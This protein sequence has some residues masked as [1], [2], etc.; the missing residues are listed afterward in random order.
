MKGRKGSAMETYAKRRDTILRQLGAV[1]RSLNQMNGQLEQVRRE[2]VRLSSRKTIITADQLR[3]LNTEW[4]D[5][6]T[7]ANAV[8]KQLTSLSTIAAAYV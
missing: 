3:R 4:G 8:A 1:K 7:S 5:L 6:A 2:A